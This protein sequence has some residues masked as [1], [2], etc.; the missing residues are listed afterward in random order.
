MKSDVFCAKLKL[1]HND[2]IKKKKPWLKK[3]NRIKNRFKQNSVLHNFQ[4]N[5]DL[6]KQKSSGF[7]DAVMKKVMP[8]IHLMKPHRS[9]KHNHRNKTHGRHGRHHHSHH[10][11][12]RHRHHKGHHRHGGHDGEQPIE[13]L[14][15]KTLFELG[16]IPLV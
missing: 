12:H 8:M 6:L 1:C 11:Q 7:R 9:V 3:L 13:K 2:Q 16:K 15:E 10:R 5:L 4:K 14:E